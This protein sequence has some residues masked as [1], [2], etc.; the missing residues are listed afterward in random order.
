MILIIVK[1][2]L[3]LKK[4]RFYYKQLMFKELGLPV[5]THYTGKNPLFPDELN[6]SDRPMRDGSLANTL[7]LPTK[8]QVSEIVKI[9]K[10]IQKFMINLINF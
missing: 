2:C 5:K 4:F 1:V 10:R 6:K 9:L 7:N 8:V 3:M